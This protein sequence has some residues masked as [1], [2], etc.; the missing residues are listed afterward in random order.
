MKCSRIVWTCCL[1]LLLLAWTVVQVGCQPPAK[2]PA[3]DEPLVEEPVEEPAEE[4]AEEPT[5]EPAEE[6]AEEPTEEPAEEP[7]AMPAE[8]PAEEPAEEPAAEPKGTP[9]KV[10]TPLGLPDVPI[11]DDNPMTV[12]K[13]E[14]GKLLYFDTRVS[15]DGT[16][17]CATCHDPQ[18]GW[19]ENRPTS[20]GIKDAEGHPQIGERNSP[21]VINSAYAT[22]MF[23]DGREPDLE[24][25]AVGPVGNSIEMG[26]SMENIV[27]QF[28][29][30][31]GYEERFQK[32]FGTG[33]T[34]EGFAKA[35]AAFE[36]TVVSGNSAYDKFKAGDE[37]ALDEAQKRGLDL[38]EDN[39]STCHTPP[40]FSNYRF[41]NAGVGMDAE[42]PDK[43]RMEAT[44]KE[45]DLGK[46]RVPALRD[47]V[48]TAPY[49]HDGK[50]E[51]LE[52]AVA[53]MAGG[54]IDNPNLSSAMKGLRAAEL[55][56]QDQADL[57]AFLKA[58]SGDYPK[59]EP[60]TQFPQ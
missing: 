43:G 27:E 13:V 23:W 54:G 4:P 49:F 17:S 48:D 31:P 59:T 34:K 12:E 22:S 55:T 25:Q 56:E 46:F 32:V 20:A 40:L 42:E 50:T 18:M 44:G 47:V 1:G 51:T 41:Y 30:I 35:V 28:A 21:T 8:Q 37:A 9:M 57:V 60:P 2:P 38:F 3:S 36:R 16:I 5:E 7:A 58:L 29:K 39:C 53:L 52:Q 24:A 14:L 33:V 11:P 15:K 45:R 19:A 6:P 26:S 10:E